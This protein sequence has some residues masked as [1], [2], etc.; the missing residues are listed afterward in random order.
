LRVF[1]FRTRF[2]SL[3]QNYKVNE[4]I[5]QLFDKNEIIVKL[6]NRLHFAI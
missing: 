2:L 6:K 1:T 4:I 3:N 5:E